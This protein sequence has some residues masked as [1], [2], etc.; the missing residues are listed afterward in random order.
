MRS[1]TIHDLEDDV[2]D[3]LE[4]QAKVH[5]R[6]VEAEL[7]DI[8]TKSLRPLSVDTFFDRAEQIALSTR[9]RAQTDSAVLQREDRDR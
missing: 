6:S 5:N 9:G 7:R 3:R 8:V 1:V 4:Q 2:L